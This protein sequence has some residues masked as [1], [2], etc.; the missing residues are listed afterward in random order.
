[1]SDKQVPDVDIRQSLSMVFATPLVVHWPAGIK[2]RGELRRQP[3]HLIDLMATCVEAAGAK[4]PRTVN[5][6]PITP[7]EGKSLLPVFGNSPLDRDALYWEHEGN[8]AIRIGRWKLVAKGR[9]G[10]WE[11]YDLRLDRTELANLVEAEPERAERM[12]ATW[13][14]WANRTQVLPRP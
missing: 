14:E 12:A 3:G 2:A 7:A 13:L 6:R 4:Y 5:R 10:A 8:R 9:K 1:M 11:L